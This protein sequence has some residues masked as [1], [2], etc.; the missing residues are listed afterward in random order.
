[1]PRFTHDELL[2]SSEEHMN[3]VSARLAVL[4]SWVYAKAGLRSEAMKRV[5]DSLIKADG[6]PKGSGG[7]RVA[8]IAVAIETLRLL[9]RER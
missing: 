6:L 1:M 7:D 4:S 3:C 2:L 9:E 5:R 8:V